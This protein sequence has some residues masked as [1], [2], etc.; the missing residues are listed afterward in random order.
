[1]GQPQQGYN[2]QNETRRFGSKVGKNSETRA[3]A[4]VV[5]GALALLILIRLGFR[6][7]NVFGVSASVN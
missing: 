1:M 4:I 7:V 6:G 3:I 2:P 5:L